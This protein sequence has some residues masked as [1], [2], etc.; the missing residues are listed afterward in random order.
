M[1]RT[2]KILIDK[3]KPSLLT[4]PDRD[5]NTPLQE[6]ASSGHLPMLKGLVEKLAEFRTYNNE[7]DKKNSFGNTPL[8]LVFQFDH[9]NM[10]KLLV[11]QGANPAIKK[12]A[13]FTALELGEKLGGGDSLS[14]LTR[15]RKETKG[16]T[17]GKTGK[18]TGKRT[19]RRTR[20]RTKKAKETKK[21]KK[22]KKKTG[23]ETGKKTRRGLRSG[24]SP[25]SLGRVC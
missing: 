5:G 20:E 24:S 4:R 14:I 15:S 19:G 11:R 13:Q 21:T 6:A 2:Y 18:R 16:K 8:H 7:I 12:N 25:R 9:P 17:K 3:S 1:S 10:V 22:T 23:E